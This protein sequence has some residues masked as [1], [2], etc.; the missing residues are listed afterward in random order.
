MLK[1]S[2]N[3]KNK[4]IQLSLDADKGKNFPMVGEVENWNIDADCIPHPQEK[5]KTVSPVLTE[6]VSRFPVS[7]LKDEPNYFH[8]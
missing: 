3:Q 2:S 1:Y 6:M 8:F 4:V 7:P 5:G